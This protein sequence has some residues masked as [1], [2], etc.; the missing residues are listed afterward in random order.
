MARG[1]H[2]AGRPFARRFTQRAQLLRAGLAL[3][4]AAEFPRVER[5]LQQLLA[6][7]PD[8]DAPLELRGGAVG[9][10]AGAGPREQAQRLSRPSRGPGR[11]ALLRG[12]KISK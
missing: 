6:A 10:D 4:V 9:G 3:L 5:A 2:A 7:K 11:S 8:A 1:R 12:V